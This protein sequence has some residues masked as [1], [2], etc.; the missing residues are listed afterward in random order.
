MLITQPHM[1]GSSIVM[2]EISQE[3]LDK[4]NKLR[5]SLTDYIITARP[6]DIP[7]KL[8]E[9]RMYRALTLRQVEI[10]TGIS[11][12]YLSQLE[13]GKISKPSFQ[14]VHKLCEIYKIRVIVGV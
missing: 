5:N 1:G 14:V 12:A 6:V 11:N 2:D 7:G 10:A 9:W 8:K 13:T 4:V 3:D